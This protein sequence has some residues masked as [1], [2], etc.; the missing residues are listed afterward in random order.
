MGVQL[1]LRGVQHALN[2]HFNLI[3]VYLLDYRVCDNQFDSNKWKLTKDNLVKTRGEKILNF[4][5]LNHWLKSHVLYMK[6]S[7]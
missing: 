5:G 3:S 7:L 1:L 6:T 2:V 4:I